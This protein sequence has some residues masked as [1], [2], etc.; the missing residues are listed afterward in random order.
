MLLVVVLGKPLIL[1]VPVGV[2]LILVVPVI[3]I[4][5]CRMI[6]NVTRPDKQVI[7]YVTRRAGCGRD[8]KDKKMTVPMI[9]CQI[10]R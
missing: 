7:W 8:V 5:H 1:R 4:E 3:V 2:P 6:W 9:S 10:A